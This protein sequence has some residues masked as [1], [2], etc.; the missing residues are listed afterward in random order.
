M[1]KFLNFLFAFL[2]QRHIDR[3]KMLK[4]SVKAGGT[5]A[6]LFLVLVGFVTSQ[7]TKDR[8]SK[9][10]STVLSTKWSKTPLVLEASE[11]LAEENNEYF[12]DFLNFLSEKE[13]IDL[14]RQTDEETYRTVVSFASRYPKYPYVNFPIQLNVSF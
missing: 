12:W 8:K 6:W 2:V 13:H 7:G 3:P 10:V 14:R 9:V 11:Y 4:L 1:E 5:W